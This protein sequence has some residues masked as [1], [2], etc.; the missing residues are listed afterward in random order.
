M[1]ALPR[2]FFDR[3]SVTVARELIG[4]YL[5]Q[6]EEGASAGGG[7]PAMLVGRIVE[8]EAY[9]QDDPASHSYR[10]RTPRAAV[11][12]GPAGTAYVYFIYGMYHCLNV[13]TEPEGIGGAVLLRAVEPLSEVERMWYRRYP[14]RIFRANEKQMQAIASGPGK[15]TQAYGIR[16]ETHNGTSLLSG[17]LVISRSFPAEGSAYEEPHPCGPVVATERIGI[18]KARE[19]LWRFIDSES[20]FLSRPHRRRGARSV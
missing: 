2:P 17:S 20:A 9:R 3:D 14:E 15:L 16:R 4:T 1:E 8:T 18:T 12:Y 5:V 19:R 13:V 11:M 10:G 7:A 6:Q